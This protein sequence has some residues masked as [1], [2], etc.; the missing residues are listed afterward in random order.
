MGRGGQR[1]HHTGGTT[2]RHWRTAV[3]QSDGLRASSASAPFPNGTIAQ[4]YGARRAQAGYSA[5][6]PAAY[7]AAYPAGYPEGGGNPKVGA[8]GGEAT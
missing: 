7:P 1:P 6:H 4:C 3:T 2:A 5:A 8:W